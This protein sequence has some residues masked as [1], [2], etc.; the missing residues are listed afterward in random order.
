MRITGGTYRGRIIQAGQGDSIR[1]TS[2]KVRQAVFNILNSW[3]DFDNCQMADLF[4]GAGT[5]SIEAISRGVKKCYSID[6][7][8]KSLSIALSNTQNLD[9]GPEQISFTKA[10]AAAP[11]KLNHIPSRSIDLVF[12]DPPFDKGLDAQCLSALPA[13]QWLKP[14]A[15]IVVE[16]EQQKPNIPAE[17]SHL[18]SEKQYKDYGRSKIHLYE[19]IPKE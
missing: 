4:C 16:T 19:F 12:L 18:I 6:I 10:N 2:D 3:I 14:G 13:C 15:M 17:V 1:P 8:R 11:D 5:M 7:S 9:I